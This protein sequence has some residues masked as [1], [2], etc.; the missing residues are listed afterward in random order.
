VYNGEAFIA[1]A[2]SSALRQ[3]YEPMEIIVVD[4]GSTDKTAAIVK[5]FQEITYVY[6]KNGGAPAARNQGLHIAKGNMIAFLDADDLWNDDK[7]NLQL[8]C[9]RKQPS[10]EI[11][12]GY[13]QRM[14]FIETKDGKHHFRN[15]LDPVLG[16]NFVASLIRRSV[17]DKVGLIDEAFPHC[18]DWDWFMRAKELNISMLVHREA[19]RFY[20]RHDNNITN[21]MTKEN[22]YK[23]MMLKNS[24]NRRRLEEKGAARTLPKLS[25]FEIK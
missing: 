16:M 25:D 17:F 21:K 10:A 7:I 22:H 15:Y 11:V 14:Q 19:V 8:A 24:L 5:S 18:D 6:Q 23:V 3:N 2:I 13:T 4:D 12:V 1:D 20:R 9:F